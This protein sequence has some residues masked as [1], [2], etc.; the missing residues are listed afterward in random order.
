MMSDTIQAHRKACQLEPFSYD[1]TTLDIEDE[2]R[3]AVMQAF[4]L[5]E[6]E[7]RYLGGML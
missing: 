3:L 5:T 6:A 7:A 2:A 4:G 1:G